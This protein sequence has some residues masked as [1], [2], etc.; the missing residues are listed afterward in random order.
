MAGIVFY[1]V[2]RA[3]LAFGPYSTPQRFSVRSCHVLVLI[4]TGLAY[5]WRSVWQIVDTKNKKET[6][7]NLVEVG[8]RFCLHLIRLFNGSFGGSTLYENPDYESP[9][10]VRACY[11]QMLF[12]CLGSMTNSTP[13]HTL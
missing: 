7:T 10:E 9:N 11:C 3:R 5:D 13:S 1:R 4:K 12:Y 8:P 6:E 2:L